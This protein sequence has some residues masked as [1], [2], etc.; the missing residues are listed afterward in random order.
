[1]RHTC[2]PSLA[3]Q[4]RKPVVHIAVNPSD[5][6]TPER[7]E[8]VRSTGCEV[9]P[10]YRNGWKLYC[11]NWELPEGRK[12]VSRM[13]DDDVL[14][15]DFCQRAYEAAPESGEWNLM[16]P[17]GYV[18][19][20]ETCFLLHHPGI[21]FVTLVTDRNTDPHQD[22]HWQYHK[23]WPSKVVSHDVGWIWVRHGD[24]ASSTLPRYRKVKKS[25]IDARRIPINLRAILRSIA[26]SGTAS[27]NYSEH[28][29]QRTL[30]HVL[31]E[32]A[33]NAR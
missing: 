24:A 25:G 2:I 1:M 23:R 27:G 9:Y 16:W 11:E 14:A 4:T 13:D 15:K 33:A 3:Y 22:Q 5:P 31:K 8:L 19:W 26:E 18:F 6:H 32:N 29:N 30:K 20:R 12:V 7:L 21:Q 28:R 17:N 10:V